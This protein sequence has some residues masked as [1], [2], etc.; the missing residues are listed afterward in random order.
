P[1]RAL[2]PGGARAATLDVSA[3]TLRYV[4]APG[5]ANL[6]TITPDVGFVTVVES[7][8]TTA[9]SVA[10]GCSITL[11]GRATCPAT[12]I[13]AVSVDLG[14]LDDRLTSTSALPTTVLDGPGNDAIS[15]GAGN[16][17]LIAGTGADTLSGGAGTDTADYGAR[18]AAVTVTLD[19]RAGDGAT[20]EGDNIG[21]DVDDITG[22]SGDDV[23]TGSNSRNALRGGAGRD[24]LDARDGDDTLDGG[25]GDDS[26]TG[27]SGADALAGGDGAD[28]LGGGDGDDSLDG[29]R[30][31]D[32][33]GGGNG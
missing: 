10:A 23:I 27:G 32:T 15:L 28:T 18:R 12:G 29:G 1:A 5:E 2:A 30:G 22:G 8:P 9:L 25:A 14:D 6:V 16:D 33:L 4:A 21:T 31:A 24:T 26:L 7:S 13:T 19:D 17:T 11:P 3:C 20:G